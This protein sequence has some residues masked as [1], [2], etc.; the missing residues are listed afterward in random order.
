VTE[1]GRLV[2]VVSMTDVARATARP[3]ET[4]SAD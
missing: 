2:G 1:G 3:G 4:T